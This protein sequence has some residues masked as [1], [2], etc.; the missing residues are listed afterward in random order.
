[1]P[2]CSGR[3]TH[4][5]RLHETLRPGYVALK[6]SL[7]SGDVGEALVVHNIHRNAYAPYG[8]DTTLSI[9]NSAVHEVDISRWLLDEDYAWVQVLSGKP[10]PD[11]PDGQQDPLLITFRTTSESWSRSRCL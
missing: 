6:A 11:V 10:G 3:A 9:N 7:A 4:H 5:A 2:N 1:M 8:L